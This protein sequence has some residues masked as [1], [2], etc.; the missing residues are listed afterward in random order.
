[1]DTAETA[2]P[3]SILKEHVL[4]E[5]GANTVKKTIIAYFIYIL[6]LGKH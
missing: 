6:D 3:T 4:L 2:W 5:L 1:M